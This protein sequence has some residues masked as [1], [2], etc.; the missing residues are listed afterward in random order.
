MAVAYLDKLRAEWL[1]DPIPYWR[2]VRAPV[3]IMLGGFDR[4]VP[5]AASTPLLRRALAEAGVRDATVRVF[6]TGNHGLLEARTG[7]D[8]E[9][10]ELA[11]YVPGFQDGLV[12][13]IEAHVRPA[14]SR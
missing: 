14:G 3:Y 1:Y 5:T 13:W 8:R 12:R 9:V 11:H 2:M 4:S 10:H 6:E 7:Y